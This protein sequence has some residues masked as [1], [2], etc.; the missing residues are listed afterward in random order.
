MVHQQAWTIDQDLNVVCSRYV[1]NNNQQN[2]DSDHHHQE[3][4]DRRE[5]I[6]INKHS[7]TH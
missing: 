7:Q 1:N 2:A 4:A 6:I 5:E 3:A